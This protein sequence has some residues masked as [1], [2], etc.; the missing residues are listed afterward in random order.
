MS[1][2]SRGRARVRTESSQPTPVA[3]TPAASTPVPVPKP[4]PVPVP[5]PAPTATAP[6]RSVAPES[7]RGRGLSSTPAPATPTQ[8]KKDKPSSSS[9]ESPPQQVSPPHSQSSGSTVATQSLGRAALRG[10][11]HQPGVVVRTE[12]LPPLERLQLQ[13]QGEVAAKPE[14]KREVRIESVLYTK[15]ETCTE[16]QGKLGEPIKILC[17]YFEVTSRPEWILYQY[18]VDFAPVIDSRSLRIGLMK[19]HD[20]MFPL[21][22]AFDGSTIYSLTKLHDPVTEV[23]STRQSDQSIIKITIKRVGEIIPTSPQFVHLFNLIFRRCLKI[24]GMMEIDRS[25]FDMENKITIPAYNL[26]LINGLSTSIANYENKLLLCAELTHK[27][28]HKSTIHDLM[29][30]TYGTSRNM[31]DFKERCA[32]EIVGRVVMTSY[33]SKTYKIDDIDWETK[34]THKF[35][36]K[37]GD[38]SFMDYYKTNYPDCKIY[39]LEQPLLVSLPSGKDKRRAEQ[40]GQ[41]AKPALLIPELC[42][43]TGVDEKMRTDFKFKRELEKFSKVGPSDRCGRLSSFV[44]NFKSNAGVKA[45]LEKWQIDLSTSPCELDGRIIP[46]ETLRFGDNAMKKLNEKADW[47]NDMKGMKLLQCVDLRDW[48][49]VCPNSKRQAGVMF[50]K[51]Y[52][53]V[54]RG[55]GI[56][57]QGPKEVIVSQDSPEQL[58][59]ALKQNIEDSTQMVV[60]IVSS[61]RKDRYDAIKRIC[62]LEK[63]VPSQV[64]TSMIIDDERKRRSVVTKVAIQMNCKLGGEV[65]QSNIPLK[66]VMICGI[67]TYHDSATK[68]GSVCAFIATSNTSYTKYFSRATIQETHQ[69]LSSNLSITVKSAC[70]HYYKVNNAYPEKLIIY[71]DGISDGQLSMVKEHEIPQ[72]EKAFSMLDANYKPLLA[73]IIVKK[74]G[75]TRFFARSRGGLMNPPCGSVID[76]VV[77]RAEWFDFYLIS[78]CVTQGTV[79]PTHYNVIHD[80]I[81]LKPDHYQRLSFKLTH[82]YYNWPGTIRVPST[83]QYAHKLAFLVGQSLHKEHH[84]SLCDKLFYL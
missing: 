44:S 57:A 77:S 28:L 60:I 21:N 68:H 54:I 58:V 73:V 80:T 81:G 56:R 26:E 32:A 75:N 42:V 53:E 82:M 20:K 83:C 27:L 55:M 34:P 40:V 18:H 8:T 41:V 38:V 69:E 76:S 10:A 52:M 66:N 14:V 49:I 79:N 11:P 19:D 16:K 25:Y 50:V 29:E 13:E 30:K 12:L 43:V 31:D 51:T 7:G 9:E 63:P 45:E 17:N 4:L 15:P 70:E 67:D 84:S 3:P 74:R 62:C 71:R 59:N 33:N 39:D 5:V 72:I 22:K 24:Y 37:R 47:G 64:C 6:T 23:A 65:W 36:T 48:V 46:P 61:K 78:Q 2:R 1:G 35:S